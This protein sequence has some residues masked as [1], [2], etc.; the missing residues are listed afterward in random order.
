VADRRVDCFFYGLFMDGDVLR[1]NGVT[2]TAPRRAYAEDYGLRI[3]ERATLERSSG[4]RAY[5]MISG[6]TES[7][8]ERLYSASGLGQYRAHGG[9]PSGAG[10]GR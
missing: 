6:L 3:G 2:P 5:G 10:H 8:L 4:H 9:I 7:E 1:E